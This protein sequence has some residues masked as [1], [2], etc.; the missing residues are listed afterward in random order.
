MKKAKKVSLVLIGFVLFIT[1]MCTVGQAKA[2]AAMKLNAKSKTIY[3]GRTYTLK[4]VKTKKAVKWKSSQKSVATVSKKGVVKG[5]KAGKAV[6]TAQ[7]GKKVLK[8]NVTVRNNVSVN[9]SSIVLDGGKSSV[10]TVSIKK[11]VYNIWFQ[12]GNTNVVSCKW[13]RWKRNTIPLTITA[14]NPGTTTVTLT[15]TYSKEKIKIT[16]KVRNPW[17]GVRVEIPGTIGEQDEP[18]N[19][20]KITGYKFYKEYASADW[21]TMDINF[22]LVQ[23]KRTGFRNWGEYFYC[24]DKNGN[25]LKKCYLYANSLALG[26]SYRDDAHIPVNTARI[27]FYEYPDTENESGGSGGDSGDNSGTLPE[28]ST[29]WTVNDMKQVDQYVKNAGEQAKNAYNYAQQACQIPAASKIYCSM[30][31][32]EM[33]SALRNLKIAEELT[34]KKEPIN[35]KDADGNPA[36]T[37]TQKIEETMAVYDGLDELSNTDTDAIFEM[38]QDGNLQISFLKVVTAKIVVIMLS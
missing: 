6:I 14:K 35:L 15:N 27:V 31:I 25:I 26:R 37:L 20:M 36:G 16:V 12:V 19:R 2:E 10:V 8:C 11:D 9:K 21:Y 18:G 30:A 17:D 7:I 38:A 23:Y 4:V 22:K 32:S 1:L 24:Y 28:D 29:K 33:E 34:K 13:G 5:I 3:V